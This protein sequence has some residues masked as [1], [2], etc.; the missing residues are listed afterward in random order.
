MKIGELATRCSVPTQT[1]RY[2]ERRGLLPPAERTANGYRSYDLAA[3]DRIRFIQR[4]QAAGLTLAEIAG[5]IHVRADGTAPCQH[6]DGLLNDKL[7]EVDERIGEL[8]QLRGDLI[9]LLD[10]SSRLDPSDCGAD[11]VCHILNR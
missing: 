8:Q 1:I 5:V 7:A 3:P 6:V 11:E 4:A 9:E 10:R 2:Y